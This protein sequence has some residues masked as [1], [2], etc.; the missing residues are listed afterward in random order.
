[1]FVDDFLLGERQR[2][3]IALGLVGKFWRPVIEFAKVPTE[4]F[5]DFDEPGYAK[6][7]DSLSVRSMDGHRT[8]LAHILANGV[9]DVTR[10]MAEARAG[11]DV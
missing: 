8:L 6:T 9:L 11:T 4:R 3:E 1:M 7:I 10:E 5:R 2:D